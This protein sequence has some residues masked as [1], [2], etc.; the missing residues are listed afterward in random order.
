M[1]E[2]PRDS[3]VS[4]T[5]DFGKIY[6]KGLL[7]HVE[8]NQTSFHLFTQ[9]QVSCQFCFHWDC[10]TAIL[11]HSESDIAYGDVPKHIS[12]P[13]MES[14]QCIVDH[15]IDVTCNEQK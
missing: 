10:L 15:Q 4:M 13:E 2:S 11:K 3:I 9:L 6:K 12:A 14:I 1:C 7:I 8:A 5:H